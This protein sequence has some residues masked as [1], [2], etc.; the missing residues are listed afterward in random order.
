MHHRLYKLNLSNFS[1]VLLH[2]CYIDQGQVDEISSVQPVPETKAAD[3][4]QIEQFNTEHS[5]SEN[6]RQRDH[7]KD[8]TDFDHTL[9]K[10]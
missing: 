1:A 9:G 10:N 5:S 7:R 8:G 3:D 4:K 2:Y 6:I